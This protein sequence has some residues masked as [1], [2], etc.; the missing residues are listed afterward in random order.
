MT[1][2]QRLSQGGFQCARDC[3]KK[4]LYRYEMCLQRR[5]GNDSP[6]LH[7]GSLWHKV[8]AEC[9]S[10]PGFSELDALVNSLAR[11]EDASQCF[12]GI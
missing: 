10:T 5:G 1:D 7:F 9:N 2:S 4:Y 3:K 8:L 11:S 12:W 6:A